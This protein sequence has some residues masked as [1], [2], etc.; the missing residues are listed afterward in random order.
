MS[1]PAW[2]SRQPTYF[3][4]VA[5]PLTVKAGPPAVMIG[6]QQI[7]GAQ[8]S[9][10]KTSQS[11]ESGKDLPVEKDQSS[12]SHSSTLWSDSDLGGSCWKTSPVS[13]LPTTEGTSSPSSMKWT[14]SGMV[15]RGEL[16]TLA[17]ILRRAGRRGKNLPE[18]LNEALTS[19]ALSSPDTTKELP[20]PENGQLV[21]VGSQVDPSGVREA[22]GLAGGLDNPNHRAMGAA[23]P[24]QEDIQVDHHAYSIREDAKAE[25]FS[26]T[27]V[28][29]ARALNAVWPSVQSHHAQTF[30]ASVYQNNDAQYGMQES[31]L[32][33]TG[34]DSSRYK[35]CGNGVVAN[36]AEWIGN[37]LVEVD[38]KWTELK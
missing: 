34:L 26:A 1:F 35:V 8:D 13:S 16:L 14:N 19:L 7:S 28:K 12:H 4:D 6:R 33:P 20:A 2:F 37:R 9:P 23:F 3:N 24:S 38:R 11:L 27:P 29:T 17:G 22:D 30:I 15:F 31:D 21:V 18:A 32:L 10:A 5:D 36:V 25:N